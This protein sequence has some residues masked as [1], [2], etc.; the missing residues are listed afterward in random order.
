MADAQF[1]LA[2]LIEVGVGGVPLQFLLARAADPARRLRIILFGRTAVAASLAVAGARS[3]LLPPGQRFAALDAAGVEGV[4]RLA[5]GARAPR[6]V[7]AY[8]AA[9]GAL[10][11]RLVAET[12][13]ELLFW[14][15][16]CVVPDGFAERVPDGTAEVLCLG[17]YRLLTRRGFEGLLEALL[18]RVDAARRHAVAAPVAV[19]GVDDMVLAEGFWAAE[20]DGTATWA[21]TGPQRTATVLL[22]PLP[23]GRRRITLFFY[24]AQLPL[25]AEAL[26]IAIDGQPAAAHYVPAEAKIECDAPAAVPGLCQVLQIRHA[27]L[28]ATSDGSRLIGV[29][30]HKVKCEAL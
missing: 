25:S 22:P 19:H 18:V 4:V 5:E 21:W 15:P 28:A 16:D 24:G 23:P 9:D 14:P 30:L 13:A 26:R 1:R 6:A 2:Q 7:A 17:R 3:V 29:A 8:A 20:S 27:R 10:A 12:G 11:A